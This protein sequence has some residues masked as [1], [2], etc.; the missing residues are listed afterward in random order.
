MSLKLGARGQSLHRSALTLP[1]PVLGKLRFYKGW[2]PMGKEER[3]GNS[4]RMTEVMDF[5]T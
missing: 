4:D 2:P 5:G 3:K 1:G